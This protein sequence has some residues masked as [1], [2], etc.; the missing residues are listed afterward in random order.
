MATFC[1]IAAHSVDHMF[2]F[3]CILTICNT[4][5]FL[6]WFRGLDLDCVC[7]LILKDDCVLFEYAFLLVL[8]KG[9]FF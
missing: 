5:H 7:T 2:S 4:S 6:F 9:P 8:V 3:I 1:E